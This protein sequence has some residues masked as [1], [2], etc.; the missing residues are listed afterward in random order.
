MKRDIPNAQRL[1][2]HPT[3]TLFRGCIDLHSGQVKQI[4]GGTLDT[5]SL[6]TNFV[7]TLPPSHFAALYAENNVLG[8]HVICLG[9]GNDTAATEALQ[10]WPGKLQVGGGITDA[11]AKMWI[12]RGA[13]K[14]GYGMD[15]RMGGG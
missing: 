6:K 15:E 13:D 11:N 1:A 3:M 10:T 9:P 7:S 4:V 5:S 8:T 14:V 12:E 2:T